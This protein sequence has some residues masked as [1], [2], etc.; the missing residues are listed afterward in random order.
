MGL[1]PLEQ[2]S[3]GESFDNGMQK[4]AASCRERRRRIETNQYLPSLRVSHVSHYLDSSARFPQGD[5]VPKSLCKW[6]PRRYSTH[7]SLPSRPVCQEG[8]IDRVIRPGHGGH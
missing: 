6:V 2:W 4:A 7:R 5:L 8:G 1:R 3:P